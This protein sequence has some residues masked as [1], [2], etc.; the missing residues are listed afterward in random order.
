[1]PTVESSVVKTYRDGTQTIEDGAGTPLSYDIA[2][3]DGDFS[4]D[5]DKAG[6]TVIYDRGAIVGLRKGNDPV[7][8]FSIT[9]DMRQ[10]TDADDSTIVD[11]C[12]QPPTGAWSAATSVAGK[13]YEFFLVKCTFT[14]KGVDNGDSADHKLIM[15]KVLLNWSFKEGDRNKITIKGEVYGAITRTGAGPTA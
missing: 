7:N 15:D 13:E 1:M 3:E 12:E 10:F 6:R 4:V 9:V 14:V 5:V 2:Y 11:I 8:A